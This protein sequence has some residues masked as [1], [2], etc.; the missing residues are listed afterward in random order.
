MCANWLPDIEDIGILQ[1]TCYTK[2]KGCGNNWSKERN[3]PLNEKGQF[4]SKK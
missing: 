2:N 1:N 4:F 3:T